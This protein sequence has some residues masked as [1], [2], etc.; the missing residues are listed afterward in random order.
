MA[1]KS[2]LHTVLKFWGKKLPYRPVD[3][4][5]ARAGAF[6]V[7]G[8]ELSSLHRQLLP[9]EIEAICAEAE[10][11]EPTESYSA[12]RDARARAASS[13]KTLYWSA[14]REQLLMQARKQNPE[15]SDSE[16]IELALRKFIASGS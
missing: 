4:V 5:R 2:A 12:L 7:L 3:I 15:T 10:A 14:E 8:T 9:G 6:R 13:T 11:I 16:L 1:E